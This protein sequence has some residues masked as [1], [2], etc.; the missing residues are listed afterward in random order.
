MNVTFKKF[1]QEKDRDDF[2]NL[3]LNMID[4]F[5]DYAKEKPTIE[6]VLEEFIFD[7]PPGIRKENKEAYL[8]YFKSELVG[9]VDYVYNYPQEKNAIIGYLVIHKNYRS[10]GIGRKALDFVI[11][12]IKE[13]NVERLNLV[14]VKNSLAHKFWLKQ[15]FEQVSEFNDNIYGAQ[16]NLI[17]KI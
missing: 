15:N 4:Y 2:Y 17:K 9:F 7:L 12:N 5:E 6:E 14:A 11:S 16:V 13:K 10:K 1:N 8:I 3:I